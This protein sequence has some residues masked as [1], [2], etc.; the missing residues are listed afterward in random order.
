MSLS[1][2]GNG[3]ITGFD[4]GASGFGGLV[5]VKHA[6]KTNTQTNS[7][8]SMDSF[9]V[10]DLSITH[11]LADSANK[12]IIVVTLGMTANADNRGGV[13]IS[14]L[15]GSTL[16]GGAAAAGSRTLL[17]VANGRLTNS[18]DS[19]TGAAVTSTFVYEPGDTAAHTYAVH[20]VNTV[21]STQTIYINRTES[22]AD[23]ATSIRSGSSLVIME[24]AV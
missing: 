3:T 24:V 12:L 23:A 14:V 20:A 10:T 6:L 22:D 4:A 8:A 11:T 2:A 16:I 7:T 21:G 1:L 5:A 17:T 13:G 15:D 9:A 18:G 19:Q